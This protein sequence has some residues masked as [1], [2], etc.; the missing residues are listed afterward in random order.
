MNDF[1]EAENLLRVCLER[2]SAVL[3]TSHPLVLSCRSEL[4]L[5]SLGCGHYEVAEQTNRIVLAKRERGP[6]LEPTTHPDTLSSQHQLAEVLRLRDGCKAADAL[7]ERV[8]KERTAIL[9]SGTLTGS[10]F[11]PDQLASLHQRAIIL[12]GLKQ[13][14]LALEKIDLALTARKT[15][16]GD[17]HP[18]T[19]MSLTWKGEIMRVQLHRYSSEREQIL[20]VIETLHKQALEGLSWIFGPEHQ[21]TLQCATHLA[22]LKTERGGSSTRET[23]DLYRQIY[24]TY[25]RTLGDLHAE[26]LKSKGRYADTL[27]A[28]SPANHVHAKKLWRETCSGFSKGYGPDAWVT[29]KAYREY[30]KFLRTYPDL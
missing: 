20:D 22:L 29:V 17:D 6:W 23:E 2:L 15:I 3:S 26:T 10:D 16:L 24:K 7:S 14:P 27:R 5:V 25:Q 12:S 28:S 30:E 1:E 11:H 9:T 18:D 21:N 4:A 19:L 13:H 8:L